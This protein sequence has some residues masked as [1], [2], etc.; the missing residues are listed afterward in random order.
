MPGVPEQR[1]LRIAGAGAEA[2]HDVRPLPDLYPKHT[3]DASHQRFISDHNRC[4]LCARCV[5]VCDEIEGAHTWDI[6]G[7]GVDCRMISDLKA[8]ASL[9]AGVYQASRLVMLTRKNGFSFSAGSMANS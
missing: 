3:V 8:G 5:R 2:G 4:V 6:M 7:R 1:Q 9:P